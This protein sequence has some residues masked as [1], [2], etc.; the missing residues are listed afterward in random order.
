MNSALL[1]YNISLKYPYMKRP[2]I[3]L[4]SAMCFP[5]KKILGLKMV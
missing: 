2:F 4:D 5:L 1:S 3:S